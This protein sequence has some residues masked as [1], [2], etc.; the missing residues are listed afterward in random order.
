MCSWARL[1]HFSVTDSDADFE[2]TADQ[3]SI[4]IFQH[5][6][7]FEDKFEYTGSATFRDLV[8]AAAT[9]DNI[10]V[11]PPRGEGMLR[12]PAGIAAS[13]DGRDLALLD[14]LQDVAALASG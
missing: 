12:R 5:L 7:K 1:N 4:R 14:H 8:F 11:T 2:Y 3:S 13:P 10:H 6:V 9:A